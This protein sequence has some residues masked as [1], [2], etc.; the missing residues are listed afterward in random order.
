V[1]RADDVITSAGY[2]IGPAEIEDCLLRHPAVSA[3]G[4]VGVPDALRTEVVTAFV[5]LRAGVEGKLELARE[6]QEHVR[7]RLGGHQYPRVV[8]FIDELPVTITGKI[9]RRELR[10]IALEGVPAA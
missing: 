10:R 1:G 2:R 6:L 4:V 8:H 5:V 3:V 7:S 9:V